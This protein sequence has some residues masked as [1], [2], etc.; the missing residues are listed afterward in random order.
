MTPRERVHGDAV[1][2]GVIV[3][4]IVAERGVANPYQQYQET[5]GATRGAKA[6][7]FGG[8]FSGRGRPPDRHG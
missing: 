8:A 6:M 7:G 1:R 3:S 2:H 4:Q 5:P